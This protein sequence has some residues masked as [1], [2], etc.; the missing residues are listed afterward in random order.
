MR[1]ALE[2]ERNLEGIARVKSRRAK[3]GIAAKFICGFAYSRAV[4]Y[5]SCAILK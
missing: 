4:S 1:A 3:I 5:A 2:R